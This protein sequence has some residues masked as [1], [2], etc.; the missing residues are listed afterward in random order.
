MTERLEKELALLRHFYP[1]AEWH[2][3][4]QN[5]WIKIPDFAIP[6]GIWNR[7]KATVCFEVPVGYP[8]TAPYAFY[9]EGGLRLKNSG[10][11]PQSYTEPAST[12]FPGTWGKFSWQHAESWRPTADL[13][14]G[15][16]LT[17][18]VQSF[19]ERLKEGA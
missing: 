7:D 8:G 17:N 1:Q 2:E 13:M 6:P 5:G 11:V 16:N 15:S 12:P 19:S 10:A 3:T 9:A 4:G 18:F 14:S